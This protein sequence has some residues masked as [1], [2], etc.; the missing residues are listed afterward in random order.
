MLY[1]PKYLPAD[2]F[3]ADAAK[4]NSELQRLEEA[5]WN[6][7]PQNVEAL[8]TTNLNLPSENN[9]PCTI[10]HDAGGVLL[11]NNASGT[12]ALPATAVSSRWYDVLDGTSP[13]SV[14]MT[15][16]R[17]SRVNI[18]GS[19]QI[20]STSTAAISVDLRILVNG[21]PQQGGGTE[22]LPGLSPSTALGAMA[23]DAMV[24]LPA[25][26]HTM[27]LQVR[28]RGQAVADAINILDADIQ[29]IGYT[30]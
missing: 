9:D 10:T 17:D 2:G 28:Q 8:A 20:E 23:A 1:V 29:A 30:R 26:V 16:L 4:L 18:L 27:T 3:V 14:T 13:L 6:I 22:S 12:T 15:L 21:A 7:G 24:V 19:A 5:L 11:Q 25:G